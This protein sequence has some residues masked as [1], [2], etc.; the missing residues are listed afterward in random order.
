MAMI[1]KVQQYIGTLANQDVA[2]F[3]IA[4]DNKVGGLNDAFSMKLTGGGNKNALT[5]AANGPNRNT[6]KNMNS[7]R[8]RKEEE[9]FRLSLLFSVVVLGSLTHLRGV[10]PF[11]HSFM[12]LLTV[13]KSTSYER[14]IVPF[15]TLMEKSFTFMGSSLLPKVKEGIY[16]KMLNT[17]NGEDILTDPNKVMATMTNLSKVYVFMV[18]M[19]AP[20][21]QKTY[22]PSVEVIKPAEL[23]PTVRGILAVLN[24]TFKGK[25]GFTYMAIPGNSVL[26]IPDTGVPKP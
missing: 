11:I 17:L 9:K 19:M 14:I 10:T 20:L 5:R 7:N 21:L 16:L 25:S 3:K 24:E 2:S 22:T 4:Y 8:T 15:M 6:R 23:E 26:M 12:E 18:S 13:Y 1:D